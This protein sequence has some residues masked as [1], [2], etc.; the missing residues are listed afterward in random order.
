MVTEEI[1]WRKSNKLIRPDLHRRMCRGNAFALFNVTGHAG[2]KTSSIT[3]TKL[4][5][6][7]VCPWFLERVSLHFYQIFSLKLVFNIRLMEFL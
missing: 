1:I 4:C 2:R 5:Q 7:I 3:G 6:T